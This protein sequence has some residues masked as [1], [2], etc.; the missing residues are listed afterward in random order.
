MSIYRHKWFWPGWWLGMFVFFAVIVLGGSHMQ[1][2]T[3]ALERQAARY[4]ELCRSV[5]I[6]LDLAARDADRG[7]ADEAKRAVD[8]PPHILNGCAT[9]PPIDTDQRDACW[10]NGDMT[11]LA[12]AIRDIVQQLP[13]E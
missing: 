4:H 1:Q 13:K 9:T 6:G 10:I 11:C 3:D 5:A 7:Y 2:Q 8:I 12:A